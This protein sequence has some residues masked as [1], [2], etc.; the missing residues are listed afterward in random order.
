MKKSMIFAMC[1]FAFAFASCE[2]NGGN[3]VPNGDQEKAYVAISLA[4]TDGATKAAGDEFSEGSADERAVNSAFVL[5]YKNGRNNLQ[6][7]Q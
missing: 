5:F 3:D 7:M 6:R 1:A 2:Q 4:T